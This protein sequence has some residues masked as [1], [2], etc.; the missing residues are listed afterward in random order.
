[1]EKKNETTKKLNTGI[2]LHKIE[3][4]DFYKIFLCFVIYLCIY[5]YSTF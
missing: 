1:M 2:V 4:I 3:Q 5:F